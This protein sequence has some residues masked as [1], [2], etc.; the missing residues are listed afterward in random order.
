M[1]QNLCH[2][3]YIFRILVFL[4]LFQ[5]KGTSKSICGFT[6]TYLSDR[7]SFERFNYSLTIVER[8][9]ERQGNIKY[10]GKN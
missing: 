3:R 1:S 10:L 6:C 5:V 8:I 9:D 2:T 4:V 7:K